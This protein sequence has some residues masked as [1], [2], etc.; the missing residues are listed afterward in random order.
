M[1]TS[2]WTLVQTILSKI[3][4]SSSKCNHQKMHVSRAQTIICEA[5]EGTKYMMLDIS[6]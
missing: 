5:D 3:Q 6:C 2:M 1:V 4:D